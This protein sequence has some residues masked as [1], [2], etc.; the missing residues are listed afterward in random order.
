VNTTVAVGILGLAAA[1]MAS[2]ADLSPAL[3]PSD[4]RARIEALEQTPTPPKTRYVE[5]K[6]GLVSATISPIAVHAGI[7]TLKQGGTAADAAATV[8][9]TQVATALGSYV[10]YAG[11]MQLTY[12]DSKTD[13]V[14]SMNA[15]WGSYRGETDPATIPTADNSG[16][17]QGRK[18]LVPGFMAGIESMHH[19]FG[20][21]PFSSLFGPAIWYSENGIKVSPV[22]ASFFSLRRAYLSRTPEGQAFMGQAG[23]SLPSVGERFVQPE[24]ARLLRSVSRHGAQIMYAGEWGREYAAAVQREGGRATIDDL[25]RYEPI[26][27]EPLSTEFSGHSVFGPGRST[28]GGF[29]VMEALN[30]LEEYKVEQM[31]SYWR[32]PKA[33]KA[34]S[35]ALELTV[36]TPFIHSLI[37]NA[38]IKDAVR[39]TPQDRAKKDYAKAVF[40]HADLI[41]DTFEKPKAANHSDAIV[42]VDRWGNIASLTHSINTVLWGTTG[43][44]VRGVPLSDAACYQQS[45]LAKLAPGDRVPNGMAPVIV[46]T[47]GKP[48]LAVASIGAALLPE[49]I[50]ILLGSLG[51]QLDSQTVMAAPPMLLNVS[52]SKRGMVQVPSG[53]YDRAF[54]LGLSSAGL[55]VRTVPEGQV[56][57]IKGTAVMATISAETGIRQSVEDSGIFSFAEAY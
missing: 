51:N 12:Y 53:R 52:Y 6:F 28:Q 20:A 5:G 42:I 4:E 41:I 36:V 44:V 15:G 10:S 47:S 55:S 40:A 14:Y 43:I 2:G 30:L 33:F 50:R 1:S 56:R 38:A 34:L 8:A 46:M 39:I 13:K 27:E 25:K 21:L 24:L 19:R 11:V 37:A 57:G 18:T 32:D 22:L 49:T 17:G 23:G 45:A 16:V 3:W 26:W 7:E 31:S 48:S 54:L 35:H 9:L 29:D